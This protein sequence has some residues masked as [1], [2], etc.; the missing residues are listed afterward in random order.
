MG[1]ERSPSYTG[2]LKKKKKKQ[3][4]EI[5]IMWEK[6]ISPHMFINAESTPVG[7]MRT[8]YH[9][10]LWEREAGDLE[11]VVGKT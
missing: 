9:G 5:I 2:K 6:I 4:A 7:S 3:N 11:T 10:N 8:W 1:I